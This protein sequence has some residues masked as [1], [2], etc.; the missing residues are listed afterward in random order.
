MER[1]LD[2]F[3]Q[4]LAFL[5]APNKETTDFTDFTDVEKKVFFFVTSI[6][7]IHVIRS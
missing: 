7:G 6:R 4:L 3:L 1:A 5:L 2:K